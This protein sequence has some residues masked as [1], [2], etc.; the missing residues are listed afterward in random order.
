M[1]DSNAV[2]T[3]INEL[4]YSYNLDPQ[5]EEGTMLHE[6]MKSKTLN[7]TGFTKYISM[8]QTDLEGRKCMPPE[9]VK[10]M[11]KEVMRGFIEK[12]PYDIPF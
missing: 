6:P 1:S 2:C 4:S 3:I 7:H 10:H 9:N 11:T 12:S 5:E 8:K